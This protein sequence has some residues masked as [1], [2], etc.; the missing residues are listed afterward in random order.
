M[1]DMCSLFESLICL[2]HWSFI[3]FV[4]CWSFYL[5]ILKQLGDF[6]KLSEFLN[7]LY[8]CKSYMNMSLIHST[9]G[10]AFSS[11]AW[12]MV[13]LIWIE[14]LCIMSIWYLY[15]FTRNVTMTNFLWFYFSTYSFA[16]ILIH[17]SQ[18]PLPHKS[19]ALAL[20]NHN[21]KG[22]FDLEM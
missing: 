9:I 8:I 7:I 4:I 18:E 13:H 11:W 6:Y 20:A 17:R 10:S 14:M 12:L 2:L 19:I 3:Y 16:V 21:R 22:M 1:K 15:M 5:Y